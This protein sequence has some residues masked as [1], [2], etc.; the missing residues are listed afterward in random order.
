MIGA[1]ALARLPRH[2][3]NRSHGID[4]DQPDQHEQCK[5]GVE[6]RIGEVELPPPSRRS[7][8]AAGRP[9]PASGRTCC[10]SGRSAGCVRLGPGRRRARRLPL[11]EDGGE[12]A[13]HGE[14]VRKAN[15][16]L[17]AMTAPAFGLRSRFSARSALRAGG[18]TRARNRPRRGRAPPPACRRNA[19]CRRSA[20]HALVPDVRVE[21][22]PWLPSK[23]KPTKRSG[24]A[25][26]PGRASGSNNARAASGKKSWPPS[27]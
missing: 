8:R 23:R 13:E 5:L 25:S 27:G 14:E 16:A 9:P 11:Q 22:R 3:M 6:E 1:C 12:D 18:R 19:P 15:T 10:T 21:A 20:E 2:L 7:R 26:S 4:R 17:V 24:V